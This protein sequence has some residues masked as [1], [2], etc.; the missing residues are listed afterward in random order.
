MFLISVSKIFA[1]DG[2]L[3]KTLGFEFRAEQAEMAQAYTRSLTAGKHLVFEAGTG[4]EK[5]WPI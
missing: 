3:E 1:K 4:V 2:D 5:A